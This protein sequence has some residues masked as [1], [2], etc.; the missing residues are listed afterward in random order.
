M[1]SNNFADGVHPVFAGPVV[2]RDGLRRCRVLIAVAGSVTASDAERILRKSAPEAKGMRL[3]AVKLLDQVED[4]GVK[5]YRAE[6]ASG[7][8]MSAAGSVPGSFGCRDVLTPCP[9]S[10]GLTTQGHLEASC[11]LLHLLRTMTPEKIDGHPTQY[12]F[13]KLTTGIPDDGAALTNALRN[14]R[15]E[16]N[17]LPRRAVR[18]VH[19][20]SLPD[21]RVARTYR[22]QYS[23]QPVDVPDHASGPDA[24]TTTFLDKAHRG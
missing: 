1:Q 12:E 17:G 19:R 6:Y 8:A 21:G 4:T 23:A 24:T 11:T 7:T 14:L 10:L 9:S 13:W 20:E 5:F 22:V 3:G 2:E 15:A 16:S 18:M